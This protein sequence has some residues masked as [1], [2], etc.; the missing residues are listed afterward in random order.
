MPGSLPTAS[1]S[2]KQPSL[3]PLPLIKSNL[4]R[5]H[6]LKGLIVITQPWDRSQELTPAVHY[7]AS[8]SPLTRDIQASRKGVHQEPADDPLDAI[9]GPY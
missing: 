6:S 1:W 9:C 2:E 7:L 4:H 8:I 5:A 3:L